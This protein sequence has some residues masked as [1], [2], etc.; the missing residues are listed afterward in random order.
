[1]SCFQFYE[2]EDEARMGAPDDRRVFMEHFHSE[3]VL[4]AALFS[5]VVA[6]F[7]KS[8]SL[9][10]AM[11]V[12]EH[13]LDENAQT[14]INTN[15]RLVG[16]VK[17][18]IELG[19]VSSTLFESIYNE[20]RISTVEGSLSRLRS[21]LG[22]SP[23]YAYVGKSQNNP[24]NFLKKQQ[25]TSSVKTVTSKSSKYEQAV[26]RLRSWRVPSQFNALGDELRNAG[27]NTKEMMFLS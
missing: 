13:F 26:V 23:D 22:I 11:L 19:S 18:Q 12:A 14:G 20:Y 4:E 27:F 5:L 17:K 16:P 8:P 15:V 2:R 10:K 1:M 6:Q 21:K 24:F 3:Y 25:T 9:F 7:R